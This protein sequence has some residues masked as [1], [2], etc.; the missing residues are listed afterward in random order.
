MCYTV[1]KERC[2]SVKED[3]RN[4]YRVPNIGACED[5]DLLSLSEVCARLEEQ[6]YALIQ[7][8][9]DEKRQVI[10]AYIS[11]RDDLEVETVKTALRWGKRHYK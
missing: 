11:A 6:V 3:L 2:D 10:E 4:L 9:P 8:L 5:V 7:T 1:A